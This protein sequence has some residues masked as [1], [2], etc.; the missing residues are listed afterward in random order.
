M[1]DIVLDFS[2]KSRELGANGRSLLNVVQ[3]GTD[4]RVV[5]VDEDDHGFAPIL[6]EFLNGIGEV[7]G[8]CDRRIID[9]ACAPNRARN[10]L[11]KLL[12]EPLERRHIHRGEVEMKNGILRPVVVHLVDGQALEKRT[13]AA[14]KTLQRGK[15]ER[16]AE[17]P[18]TGDE[19]EAITIPRDEGIEQRGLILLPH[20]AKVIGSLRDLLFFHIHSRTPC[21]QYSIRGGGGVGAQRTENRARV[22][23]RREGVGGLPCGADTKVHEEPRRDT[24]TARM[25]EPQI[26]QICCRL[27]AC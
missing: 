1:A 13:L 22:N 5:L 12:L 17:T 10:T 2:I 6:G 16:F 26:P 9:S 11:H 20:N 24:K 25:R 18:R 4:G 23:A 3:R 27:R 8:R 15:H 7:G 14:E 21:L 19:K